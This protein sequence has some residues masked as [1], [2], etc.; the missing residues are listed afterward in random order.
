MFTSIIESRLTLS[1]FVNSR[2]GLGEAPSDRRECSTG[3]VL[4]VVTAWGRSIRDKT[5]PIIDHRHNVSHRTPV[6]TVK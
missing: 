6:L 5:G 3:L 2:S 4:N 1:Q